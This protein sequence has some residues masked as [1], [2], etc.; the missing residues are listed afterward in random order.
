MRPSLS[1]WLQS[2]PESA[3]GVEVRALRTSLGLEQFV[4]TVEE[5]RHPA[6]L[7]L[8]R[9]WHSTVSFFTG[10]GCKLYSEDLFQSLHQAVIETSKDSPPLRDRFLASVLQYPEESVRGILAW[11][12]LDYLPEE[13]LQPVTE[14][15]W[16]LLEPGGVF[17]G[18]FHNSANG[19][20]HTR[21]RVADARTV[22][23]LPGAMPMRLQR[24][25]PNRAVLNLFE[26][27]HSSRTFVGRDNLREF[28]VVK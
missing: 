28:L 23:L 2:R 24:A 5:T 9:V 3:L 27:A 13:L 1:S 10:R 19:V 6:V 18:L 12:L 17:L 11:D 25:M 21:Y 26:G 7:D 16:W 15:L 14:R 20:E 22:E 8:G 4:E